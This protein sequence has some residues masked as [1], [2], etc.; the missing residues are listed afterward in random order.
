F[1]IGLKN[2]GTHAY[3]YYSS[4]VSAAQVFF[5]AIVMT[6]VNPF[7]NYPS[8]LPYPYSGFMQWW[9]WAWAAITTCYYLLARRENRK[10]MTPCSSPGVVNVAKDGISNH[11]APGVASTSGP[12]GAMNTG[13]ACAPADGLKYKHEKARKA[14]H[15]A[16]FLAIIS[17]LIVAPVISDLVEQAIVLAGPAYEIIWGPISE[18]YRFITPNSEEAAVTLTLFALSATVILVMFIDTFRLLAGDEYSIIALLERRAGRL[19]R[20]KERGGPGAQDYIAISSTC[21]WLVGMA[22]QPVLASTEAIRIA[23]AS[24]MM[25]TLADGAAAIVGK[26]RGH[27]K[28]QRPH[29][30]VKSI[31]GLVAGFVVAFACAIFFMDWLV[32]LVVAVVFLIID[33]WSP[34]VAD[35]AI[36]PVILTLVG[37]L[38]ALLV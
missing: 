34:P 13:L 16:G 32:A 21:A 38:V 5:I 30:Q 20:D 24:I 14:F 7:A 6:F 15:L 11:D 8:M 27:H 28:I 36:N 10:A 19:L 18:A 17:Y 26:A 29:D 37:C 2:K 3:G 23:L 35:N 1:Y 22:F 31:E 12:A 9:A 25:S 4:L 33:Y